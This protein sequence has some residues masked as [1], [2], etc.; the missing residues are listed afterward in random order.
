M[1]G[2]AIR[3]NLEYKHFS[4]SPHLQALV[5]ELIAR[6][7]RHTPDFPP[8][9]RFL[10]LFVE[11]NAARSLYRVSLTY[12]VPGRTL[13]AKAER[14]DAEE[15]VREAFAE[16]E[17]QLERHKA[18]LRHADAYE[19]RGRRE[20]AR[21]AR[22][23]A[24]PAEDRVREWF[25]TQLEPHLKRLYD[26]AR[27]EIAYYEAVGDL[28]PGELAP[29]EVVDAIL[30]RAYRQFTRHPEE[31]GS[32]RWLLQLTM[33]HLREE[34]G[35]RKAE[36]R[37]TAARIEDDVPDRPPDDAVGDEIFEF[38]QPDEDL[39]LEDVLPDP[40]VPAP[41][42]AV[43][44]REMLRRVAHTLAR[45]PPAWRRTF[46]LHQVEGL[47]VADIAR[48]TGRSEAEVERVLEQTRAY[49]RQGLGGAGLVSKEVIA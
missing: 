6:L 20:A 45:L 33:Q 25:A 43:E 5:K 46:V 8:D 44:R 37:K 18:S 47:S 17:R 31:T 39:R 36:R 10:R 34:V 24:V 4:P 19:R 40:S 27:R 38:F 22:A 14:H 28:L 9:A 41:E 3:H 13:A 2:V 42:D 21:L 7:D 32:Y 49:L 1:S 12:E 16:I 15:A 35:R 23:G 11:A 26:F 29:E 30:P 48:L